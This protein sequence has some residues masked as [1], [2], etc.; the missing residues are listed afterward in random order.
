[1]NIAGE[2]AVVLAVGD[3]GHAVHTGPMPAALG[4]WQPTSPTTLSRSMSGVVDAEQ[5]AEPRRRPRARV[6]GGEHRREEH[7]AR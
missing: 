7:D 2:Q 6:L 1:M 5:A 3:A 4:R